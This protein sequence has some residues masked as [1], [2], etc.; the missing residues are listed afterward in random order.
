MSYTVRLDGRTAKVLDRLPGD[1]QARLLR[2]LEAFVVPPLVLSVMHFPM[3]VRAK[4][5]RVADGVITTG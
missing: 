5:S 4:R 3:T 2:K 1:M